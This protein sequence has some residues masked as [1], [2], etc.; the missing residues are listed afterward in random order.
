MFQD[1]IDVVRTICSGVVKVLDYGCGYEPVLK[2]L[3]LREGYLAEEY[4]TYFFPQ[5]KLVPGYDLII[6]TET[7]EHFREPKNEVDKLVSLL[8][9]MG[10]LAVMT[11]FFPEEGHQSSSEVFQNWYYQRDPTHIVFY[12]SH[13]F[14]WIAKDKGLKIIYNNEKDFI[15]LQNSPDNKSFF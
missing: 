9:P 3:L 11:R 12:S 4:D 10:Y 1:K 2:T 14:A 6:S 13:T 15:I 8:S 5:R 7:F